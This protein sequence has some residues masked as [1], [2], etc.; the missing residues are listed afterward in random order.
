M[1]RKNSRHVIISGTGRAGTT[2]LVAILTHLDLDT[3]FTR[4]ESLQVDPV[5]K[6]G[7]EYQLNDNNAPYIVKAPHMCDY[8]EEFLDQNPSIQIDYAIVPIRDMKSAA[9]SREYNSKQSPS[10]PPQ[11]VTGGL[12]GT[13]NPE[14]QERVL[15]VKLDK[16]MRAICKHKIPLLSLEYPKLLTDPDYLFE[17]LQIVFP[18]IQREKF[19]SAYKAVYNPNAGYKKKIA[20]ME[21][22][23]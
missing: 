6:G 4:A 2:P 15:V 17:N 18:Q 1:T 16:L 21:A 14:E 10:L 11:H 7:L 3:G 19:D 9:E 5:S 8:L 22:N 12:W 13:D 23:R 20:A